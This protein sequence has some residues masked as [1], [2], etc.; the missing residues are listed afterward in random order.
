[1]DRALAFDELNALKT[2]LGRIDIIMGCGRSAE[3]LPQ[4]GFPSCSANFRNTRP[5]AWVLPVQQL[6]L[7]FA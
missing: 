7:A 6:S 3:G 4:C 1:M 5:N 2:Y